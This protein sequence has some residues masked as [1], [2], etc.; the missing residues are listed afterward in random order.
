M[1]RRRASSLGVFLNGRRIGALH[2]A[3]SGA[4]AFEY[5]A[6]WLAWDHAIPVSLSLPLRDQ[7]Y[8]G[9]PVIA[10][11]DNLLPDNDAIRLRIAERIGAEG[12]DAYSL[13][14]IVGRD[15]VGALQFLDEGAE[16]GPV[17]VVEAVP[18]ADAEIADL[19]AHLAMA[20]LGLA[21]DDAFRIS[22]A[23]AQEKTALLWWEGHWHKPLG[24]TPTT[25]IFKPQIGRLPNGI[26]LSNSVENEH[27]CLT[28]LGELGLP[29]AATRIARFADAPVLVVERFDRLHA[30]D[31]R[32]L[33]RPQE[34]MCQALSVPPTRKYEDRGGPGIASIMQLLAASD[35]PAEDRARFMTAM[36]TF[37]LLGASDGHAKNFSLHLTPG[38]R[39]R[40]APLYDVLSV[41]P[42]LA[43]RQ[44]DSKQMRLAMAIGDKRRYRI[45]EIAPRHFLQSAASAGFAERAML[46]IFA[47]LRRDGEG[48]L[49]RAIAVMPAETP[50]DVIDPIAD[51]FR[52]RLRQI[53]RL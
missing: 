52:Q 9:A 20:P 16:P 15:C 11:F 19:L 44:I 40:M 41:D 37:W 31:G 1:A 3:T 28:L 33:R 43:A 24:T 50:G 10:V 12:T 29:V 2:R 6:D 7:R 4:V 49:D 47:R 14:S 42:S 36:A 21:P 38:G 34:D 13:L 23:G 53:D 30:R 27:F 45:G 8:V 35:D 22:I 17:G 32:L 18:L 46:D 39:F 26:D 51:A 5:A 25:H 48:A